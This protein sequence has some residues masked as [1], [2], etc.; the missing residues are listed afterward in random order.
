[1]LQIENQP[2]FNQIVSD[3]IEAAI[4]NSKDEKTAKRWT[5]A[6]EK[7][8]QKIEE[9]GEFMTY[10]A[11]ENYLL[12][13]SDSNEIYSANGVCSCQAYKQGFPCYHRAAARLVRLYMES[14]KQIAQV[15][16]VLLSQG[17]VALIDAEDAKRVLQYKWTLFS[18]KD[19]NKQT[20]YAVRYLRNG[21]D[22][23]TSEGLHRFIMNE[24]KGFEV[25]HINGNGLDNRKAN[26][27]IATR[28]QN[29]Q[30]IKRADN[31]TGF[32]GVYFHKG[33]QLFHAC[34]SANGQKYSCGYFDTAEEA[35]RAYDAKAKE[36]HKEFAVL[37]FPDFGGAENTSPRFP[38]G[39]PQA[40]SNIALPS[41]ACLVCRAKTANAET[42]KCDRCEQ[43]TA[44]YLKPTGEIKRQKIGGIWV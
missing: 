43:E 1:M 38:N 21:K 4:T 33:N 6:I 18:R 26:L 23:R 29:A 7:A 2:K 28:A 22:G 32:K 19:R 25:D 37:N 11:E 39:E 44:P 24:P 27:R 36:L 10:F 12:I 9:R 34:I 41:A 14:E 15:V 35:A 30:N 17:R 13:W 20:E 42:G 16:E 40:V 31:Q 3:A 8:A 5:N